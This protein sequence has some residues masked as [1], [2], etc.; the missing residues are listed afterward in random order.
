MAILVLTSHIDIIVSTSSALVFQPKD[1]FVSLVTHL[2][3]K[4]FEKSEYR[5]VS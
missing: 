2:N 1:F 5:Y 3:S 4:K